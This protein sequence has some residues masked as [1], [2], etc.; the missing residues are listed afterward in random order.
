MLEQ[1]QRDFPQDYN[2]PA[3]LAAA[4]FAMKQNEEALKAIDR[5][6]GL[7]YGPRMLRLYTLKA[8]I[9]A[10]KG[11]REAERATVNQALVRAKDFVLAGSL[12]RTKESLEARAARLAAP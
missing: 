7:A 9:L 8:D 4:L 3:R 2:P 6:L 12:L 10:A 5:A 11:D 1:S